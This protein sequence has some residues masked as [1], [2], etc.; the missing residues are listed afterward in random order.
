MR[1]CIL[2]NLTLLQLI[3]FCLTLDL[4]LPHKEDEEAERG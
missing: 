3:C 2:I 1:V 4:C